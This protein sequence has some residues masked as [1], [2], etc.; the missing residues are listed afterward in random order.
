[1]L[2]SLDQPDLFAP[3]RWPRRPYCTDDFESF[4]PLTTKEEIR[5][6]YA[7]TKV[8]LIK[9]LDE[10]NDFST[11]L[12]LISPKFKTENVANIMIWGINKYS[13]K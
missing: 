9:V 12:N 4:Y 13:L 7:Q 2:V 5:L 3:D 6:D 10:L 1:M 11:R 8:A